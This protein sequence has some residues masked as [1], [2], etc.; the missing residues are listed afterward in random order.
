MVHVPY[1]PR[2]FVLGAGFS[3]PADL[4]LGAD[5]LPGIRAEAQRLAGPDNALEHSLSRYQRYQ[6]ET[7]GAPHE[8]FNIEQFI[9]YVD[10]KHFLQLRWADETG[11][12]Y[13]DHR[14]VR[15]ATA[16]TLLRHTPPAE[17]L[18]E[19]YHIFA[20]GLRPGDVIL[21]F[22]Y[23]LIVESLLTLHNLRYQRYPFDYGDE[24]RRRNEPS[25]LSSDPTPPILVMKL[26]GSVDWVDEHEFSA[27]VRWIADQYDG[28][29]AYEYA[30]D[31]DPLGSHPSKPLVDSGEGPNDPLGSI[32]VLL[33]PMAYF[34]SRRASS[35]FGHSPMILTP[36]YAKLVYGTR[37]TPLWRILSD[38]SYYI[39]GL[40]FI[41][42]SMSHGDSHARQAI[43][44][45]ITGY[46]DVMMDP[47]NYGLHEAVDPTSDEWLHIGEGE[48]ISPIK[49][50]SSAQS[51]QEKAK[52]LEAYRFFPAY[53]T[54]FI[55]DGFN[56]AAARAVIDPLPVCVCSNC[57]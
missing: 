56:P 36:S 15:Q 5:L 37:L 10:H 19:V 18:P 14:L 26:H 41:G 9:E 30:L 42:Y 55:N 16:L 1:R 27:T 22:N 3:V 13:A 23:D 17:R 33:E 7:S 32:Q 49:V 4:P 48:T 53:S 38:L 20:N 29:D 51:H 6:Q 21:T 47:E 31:H 24:R 54:D 35:R 34:E 52:L 43:Y 12:P 40:A 44:D 46:E 57:T 39:S 45:L 8:E 25:C 50:V 28:R 11:D 2:V